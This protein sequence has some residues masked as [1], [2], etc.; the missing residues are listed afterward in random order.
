MKKLLILPLLVLLTG[1]V[2]YYYPE[3]AMEDGVYYAED[4]PSYNVYRSYYPGYNY[5][6]WSTID[7]FYM[8]YN[9][10]PLFLYY[11]GYP[12]G[13]F[14][15]SPW[16]YPFGYYGYYLPMYASHYP[17][18]PGWRPYN[19]YCSQY[20]DCDRGQNN[21]GD[22]EQDRLVGNG[23]NRRKLAD[24]DV[25]NNELATEQRISEFNTATLPYRRHVSTMP[26][27]KTSKAL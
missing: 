23:K 3:T 15:Y 2:T 22:D 25:D 12:H 16:H 27:N 13:Y 19:G 14:G 17:Y 11:Y 1:C 26:V 7:Y 9:P 6:P 5:Y 20:A 18:Y 21:Y 10:Y 8:G 4:D 24:S